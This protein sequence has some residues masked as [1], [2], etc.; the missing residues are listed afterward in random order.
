M[1]GTGPRLSAC[2]IA[3]NE[4]SRLERCLSSLFFADEIVLVDGGSTDGTPALAERLGATVHFRNFDTFIA[5]KN[6][7]VEL[8]GGDWILGI[9]A[10]EVVSP[11]LAA[12]VRSRIAEADQL[13]LNAFWIPRMSF[14]LGQWIR[15]CGWYPEWKLRLFR[16]GSGHFVGDA[17]HERV[18]FVGQ[19]RRLRHHIQ[20]Y[21]YASIS[22]HLKRID[23]YST[24]VAEQKHARGRRSGV[25]WAILKSISKFW[26]TYVYHLGFLDG[27]AGL[28]VSVLA[29]YYNFLKY[30]KLWELRRA[31]RRV[32]SATGE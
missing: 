14:Y 9:D 29:G 22:D 1:P 11:E 12:E 19:S 30:I 27:R 8:A 18:E 24:A 31:E 16:K 3:Q 20:H 5:Q 21:S 28:V 2:V 13:G 7:A 17:V 23:R 32:T 6:H 26:I 15:H 4:E 10:D 25:V